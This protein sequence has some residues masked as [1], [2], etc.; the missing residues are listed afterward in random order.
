MEMKEV[1]Y[2][3]L[4]CDEA[5]LPR[6]NSELTIITTERLCV[7]SRIDA[8]LLGYTT[9]EVVEARSETGPLLGAH[10][11][12]GNELSLAGTLICRAVG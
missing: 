11:K 12:F 1:A 10:D 4:P 6:E 7:G 3:F 2:R 5:G 8:A 9:W